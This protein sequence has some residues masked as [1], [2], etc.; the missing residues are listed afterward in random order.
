MFKVKNPKIEPSP[1]FA[2]SV[3]LV[4]RLFFGVLWAFRWGIGTLTHQIGAY[5]DQFWFTFEGVLDGCKMDAVFSRLAG[6]L[7]H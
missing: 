2:S 4:S 3:P 6:S 1:A 5:L 7:N